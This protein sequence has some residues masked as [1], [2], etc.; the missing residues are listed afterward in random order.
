[1]RAVS[2]LEARYWIA[3]VV[4]FALF[5]ALGAYVSSRPP[6]AIDLA[7]TALRGQATPVAAFFTALGRT[8]ALLAIAAGAAA[9][10]LLARAS[11]LPVLGLVAAQMLSQ[12]LVA[13]VKPLFHRM[14]P[15]HFLLYREKD[16]SFPSGHATTSVVFFLG[17]ALLALRLPNVPRGVAVGL[18]AV[19]AFCTVAIPWSRLALGAHYATDV[20]GGLLVGTGTLCTVVALLYRFG[21]LA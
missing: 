9:I 14:R 21:A 6:T 15:D 18:A 2:S 12:G 3:A 7:A 17:L 8:K 13:A 4:A 5:A 10:A 16:L 19:A 11:V 20:T 1:M